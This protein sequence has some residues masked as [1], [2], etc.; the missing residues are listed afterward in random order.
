[1]KKLLLFAAIIFVA[2]N[3]N[4]QPWMPKNTG[5]PIKY[6]DAVNR[7]RASQINDEPES[8]SKGK[9]EGEGKE[10]L[11]ETWN[12]YWKYHLDKS[13][14]MV[15]PGQT[16]E[17][18]E[19]YLQEHRQHSTARTTSGLP[20]NW[21]FQGPS[22]SNHG[23]WGI[24]RINRVTFDPIDSNTFYIGAAGS[25]TWKTTDGGATWT[26]LY[27]FLPMLGVS[28]IK[29]NPLNHNTVYVATGDGDDADSYSTGVI[30]SHNA[31]ASWASTG[32]TWPL[33]MYNLTHCLLINPLDTNTI[34]LAATNGLFKTHNAGATWITVSTGNF[35]QI[36]YNPADTSI[37]YGTMYTDTCSQ[38]MRS[39]DGGSTWTS[40]TNFRDAQRINLAVC[41]ANTSIV[42]ALVS[43]N[44]SGLEGVYGSTDAGLSYTA[45][46]TDDST[47]AHDL[48]G[49]DISLPTL[50]CGGQGWYDLCIAINPTNPNEVTIGGVNTYHSTDGGLSWVLANQWYDGLSGVS[51]VHADKHCLAYNPLTGALF[52]T[53]DGGIYKT[54]SPLTDSWNDLSNGICITE[55]YRIAV[56]NGVTFCIGG[57][58]DNGTFLVDGTTAVNLYGG[59]GMQPLINYGDPTNIWYLS[60]QYGATFITRDAG[61]N[62][63]S[64]SDTLHSSGGWISP[65]LLHP[66]DT[67]TLLMAYNQVYLSHNNGLSWTSISP[68]FDTNS[69]IDRLVMAPSNPNVLYLSYYDYTIWT[70]F[71]KYSTNMGATW[72]DIT[73]PFTSLISD[74]V[75]DPVNENHIWATC[76][77][78]GY[79]K[80][81]SY[82]RTTG[83]WTNESGSLP[84]ISVNCMLIDTNSKTKYIGTD[85]AVFYKD[86]TM[87]DWALF[88]TNLP[89]V[90]V[91]DLHINYATN[92][93]WAATY[94]RGLWKSI[95]SDHT[96]PLKVAQVCQEPNI[97]VYPNPASTVLN[98]NCSVEIASLCVTD[99]LGQTKFCITDQSKQIKLDISTWSPGV[100]FVKVN[101]QTVRKFLK[102]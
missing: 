63:T 40:V 96:I 52:E 10:H 59:D 4:G 14:Y 16:V 25:N 101:G 27:S 74:L 91:E 67:A 2:F 33:S 93:L 48:L 94:G 78:Y 65:Y 32:L 36:I 98:I 75:V 58:Q 28:D 42:K 6:M 47:C 22:V 23:Y 31:G 45:L 72:N 5:A 15:P 88:N 76:T 68:V 95:K 55:F 60:Y 41:P 51:T 12:Q 83:I 99:L 13:G 61:I 86:S 81:W 26:A 100:Y 70:P 17:N 66:T 79:T 30:V 53:C 64:I 50:S 18:W 80:V 24:G 69:N 11:F 9:E 49:Y 34:M 35:K 84:D 20:S 8:A 29:I 71:I 37:V 54:Y 43:N 87:S 44:A 19:S 102:Q 46:Y 7:Y 38:I 57:A 21:Q 62:W 92:E 97:S 56:D 85:V 73:M 39:T 89:A 82:N 1:M 3:V 90:H 77:W